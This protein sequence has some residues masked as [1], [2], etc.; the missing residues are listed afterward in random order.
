[1][2]QARPAIAQLGAIWEEQTTSVTLAGNLA[3]VEPKGWLAQ[4]LRKKA[5]VY[6]PYAENRKK[7]IMG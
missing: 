2:T 6:S 1:L 7:V 3:S 5:F 4:L